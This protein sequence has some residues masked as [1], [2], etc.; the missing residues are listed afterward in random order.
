MST[1]DQSPGPPLIAKPTEVGEMLPAMAGVAIWLY[2]LIGQGMTA[3]LETIWLLLIAVPLGAWA[4]LMR[5]RFGDGR[6][7]VTVG[8]WRRGVDLATVDSISWTM[9]GGGLSRGTILVRDR[10]GGR[11]PIYV[12][13]YTDIE[14]W[15]P[16]LLDAARRSGA[17]VD[18]Q[19]RH[20]SR[21]WGPRA[22]H[23]R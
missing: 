22:L 6:L 1:L 2:F 20:L 14:D 5:L 3:G 11:V 21:C 7:V 19:A 9:T 17:I 12:G 10:H 8:P 13:R 18:P 23:R 15:G 16:R 4:L